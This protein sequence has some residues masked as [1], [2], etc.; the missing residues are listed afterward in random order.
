[1]VFPSDNDIRRLISMKESDCSFFVLAVYSFIEAYMKSQMKS[2]GLAVTEQANFGDICKSY[3]ELFQSRFGRFTQN[4]RDFLKEMRKRKVETNKVRHE[5]A[6][7]SLEEA[8][9]AVK[10]L[11]SF[12]NIVDVKIKEKFQPLEAFL[13]EWTGRNPPSNSA[14]ELLEANQRIREL[15]VQ[16][17]ELMELSQEYQDFKVE[18]HKL[19]KKCQLAELERKDSEEKASAYRQQLQ[20]YTRLQEEAQEKYGQYEEYISKLQRMITYTR[21]RNDFERSLLRLTAEQQ[22]AVDRIR[23]KKDYLVKGSA[24]T[25]KSL[26]LLKTMEKLLAQ[27][28]GDLLFVTF[29]KSL[30]KYNAY[31]ASL[32]EMGLSENDIKTADSFF[33]SIM[34]KIFPGQGVIYQP[35]F[36]GKYAKQLKQFLHDKYP[37]HDVEVKDVFREATT[38]VWPNMVTREEYIDQMIDRDGQLV[39]LRQELRQVYWDAIDWLERQLDREQQWWHEYA[40]L[41]VAR[42]LRESPLEDGEKLADHVFVDESQDLSVCT[43]SCIKAVC[44]KSLVL[45]GDRDQSIYRLPFPMSRTGIDI[46]G[47]SITLKTNFRNTVQINQVAER[48]RSLIP[49]MSQTSCPSPFRLGPPVELLEVDTSRQNVYSLMAQ[50]V[51]LCVQ[52]LG[53]EPGNVCV[54]VNSKQ[55]Q[56]I[57][58]ELGKLGLEYMDIKDMDF[59]RGDKVCVSTIQACKGLDFPVV[60]LLADHRSHIHQGSYTP[61]QADK[62]ERNMFYVAMTR[63]MDMLTVVTTTKSNSSVVTDIRKCIQET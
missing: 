38:F 45:A 52:E 36:Q 61:E 33:I 40:K 30:V 60:V 44:R 58:Q 27:D 31:V 32:M 5:F 8:R 62:L 54:I 15:G 55:M 47:T 59:S 42:T 21:T 11:L 13:Q 20:E 46:K 43:L 57:Q 29:T 26:M 56:G 28:Q 6:S 16:L 18:F 12:Y 63:A 9:C 1:M 22:E 19:E 41:R 51:Q 48:Y 34:E 39:P 4:E 49:G 24:G 7:L 3:R 2:A 23:F 25:G 53:Y 37:L 17:R 50:R 10:N 14:M 35:T